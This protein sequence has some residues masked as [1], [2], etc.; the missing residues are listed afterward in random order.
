MATVKITKRAQNEI[1]AVI[2]N[3]TQEKPPAATKFLKSLVSKFD[4]L[5]SLPRIGTEHEEYG[6]GVRTFPFG[7]YVI[8]YQPTASGVIIVRFLH[9]ARNLPHVFR[10]E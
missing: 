1:K 3:I 4:T 7:S 5:A 2:F 6:K 8:F 10:S 9:G